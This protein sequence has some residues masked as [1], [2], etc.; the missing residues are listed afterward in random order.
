LT[1]GGVAGD[2]RR[3]KQKIGPRLLVSGAAGACFEEK[4]ASA[5]GSRFKQGKGTKGRAGDDG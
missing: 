3:K 4:P 5:L 2:A 1:W